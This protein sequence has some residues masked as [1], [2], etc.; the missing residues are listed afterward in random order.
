MQCCS[1][2]S[3]QQCTGKSPDQFCLNTLWATMHRS[4]PMQC[5]PGG[6][7]QHCIRKNPVQCCLST[8]GTKLHRSKFYAMLSKRFQTTLHKKKPCAM[9][10]QYSQNKIAQ[11]KIL[12][13]V[14]QEIPDNIVSKILCNVVLILMGQHCT[15]QNLMQC[16][17]NTLETTLHRSKA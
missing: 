1:R 11:V 7:R 13:N 2:G 15:G 17:L 12:C 14:V 6:Y 8:L 3:R 10:P 5:C 9:L 16:F 4:K